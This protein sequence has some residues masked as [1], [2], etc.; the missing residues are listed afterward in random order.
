M[1]AIQD[2]F[3]AAAASTP[4][5]AGASAAANSG[6][7]QDRFLKLLVTQLKNQDPLN[8]LDNAQITSQLSQISTVTGIEKLNASLQGLSTSALSSQSLQSAALIGRTVFSDGNTLLL[9]AGTA[10]H[11]GFELGGAAGSVR[12]EVV[13]PTG[14]VVRQLELGPQPAGFN[15]FQWDGR[16]DG[17][18]SM[19]AGNYT[20]RVVAANGAQNIT[21]TPLAAGAVTSVTLGGNGLRL[22]IGGGG[23]LTM[24]QIKRIM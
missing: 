9:A 1:S 11:G 3:S 13:A 2:V 12:V 20:F 18:A 16:G 23:D 17:G 21:A 8:P 4:A 6:E 24:G 19:T 22:N 14:N 5:A 15:T 10:A 7:I